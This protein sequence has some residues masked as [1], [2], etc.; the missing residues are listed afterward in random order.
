M[1]LYHMCGRSSELPYIAF[2]GT[3]GMMWDTEL[4]A[5]VLVWK[6]KKTFPA[7]TRVPRE[8]LQRV[9]VACLRILRAVGRL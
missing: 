4:N 1:F 9:P 6:E 5:L 8:R 3:D 2:S 7:R